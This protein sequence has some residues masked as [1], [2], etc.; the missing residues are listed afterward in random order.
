[1]SSAEL[2]Q[3]VIKV[4]DSF[5]HFFF[6]EIIWC[7]KVTAENNE[8]FHYEQRSAL[9]KNVCFGAQQIADPDQTAHYVIELYDFFL[10]HVT[11][12]SF[13]FRG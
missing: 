2:A 7:V 6:S 13:S 11:N 12:K 9:C 10:P 4:K 1:M 5:S 3:R 8:R